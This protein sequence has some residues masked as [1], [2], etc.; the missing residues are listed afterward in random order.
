MTCESD[1]NYRVPLIPPLAVV[2]AAYIYTLEKSLD[3]YDKR[4]LYFLQYSLL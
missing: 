3:C 2:T 4:V 1:I